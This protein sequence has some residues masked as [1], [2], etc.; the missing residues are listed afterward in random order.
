MRRSPTLSDQRGDLQ[1]RRELPL[2]WEELPAKIFVLHRMQT[3]SRR[4]H[5]DTKYGY[6][7]KIHIHNRHCAVLAAICMA[8]TLSHEC[9][10]M[11]SYASLRLL[12]GSASSSAESS[13]QTFFAALRVAGRS[14]GTDRL[15]IA[16]HGNPWVGRL[17]TQIILST[18]HRQGK[19]IGKAD[20]GEVCV[21]AHAQR[22]SFGPVR[23][24]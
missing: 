16:Q 20:L 10:F 6:R 2:P 18:S 19:A 7:Y 12:R 14:V 24:L 11:S 17:D 21:Y 1:T 22:D 15:K 5:T 8:C 3:K 4:T 9:L 13:T 23:A